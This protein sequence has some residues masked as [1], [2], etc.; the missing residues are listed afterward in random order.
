M[1]PFNL[2]KINYPTNDRNNINFKK[3]FPILRISEG[4][5]NACSYCLHPKS[6][7][8]LKSKPLDECIFDYKRIIACGYKRISIHANDPASYGLDI[9][10]T[11]LDL[12]ISLEE[13]TPSSDIK[14]TLTI[15]TLSIY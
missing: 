6:L 3:S 15:F 12:L 14:W 5:N 10:L 4:C 7:G 9:G 11:Y 1:K 8:K 13:N 2:K